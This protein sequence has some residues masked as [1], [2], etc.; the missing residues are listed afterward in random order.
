MAFAAK[1]QPSPILATR[2][3]AT[4]GPTTR[5]PL[6]IEEFSAM[7][8]IRS[9]LPT[10]SI[11]KDCRPGISKAFTTPSRPARMKMCHTWTCPLNVSQA[12]I[13]AR[14][15]EAVRE[16]SCPLKKSW[17]FR[18]R[19]ARRVLAHFG[20]VAVFAPLFLGVVEFGVLVTLLELFH[21]LGMTAREDGERSWGKLRN[22]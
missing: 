1:H 11:R 16:T 9:S 12:R 6:N 3:P 18:W 22:H 13:P 10:M 21:I 14:I 4:A 7:A 20:G 8:F 2:I 5:A 19:R 17:K 15:M